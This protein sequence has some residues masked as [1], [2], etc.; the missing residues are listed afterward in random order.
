MKYTRKDNQ[1]IFRLDKGDE[2]LQSLKIICQ[3]EKIK[4]GSIIGIGA[5]NECKI[6][7]YSLDAKEYYLKKYTGDY[8]IVSFIGNISIMNNDVYLHVHIS[9]AGIDNKVI[10]GHLNEC[11]ISATF[12]GIINIID[13]EINRIK[14][15][16][17][18]LNLV[19]FN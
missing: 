2:V 8:E 19:K 6:G 13:I 14:D 4:C 17:S 3:K 11:I 10:G 12:E 7:V 18:G 1:I 9:I 15:E 5:T 16:E